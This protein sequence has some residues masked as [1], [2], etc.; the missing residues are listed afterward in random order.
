[1]KIKHTPGPWNVVCIEGLSDWAFLGVGSETSTKAICHIHFEATIEDAKVIIPDE[2]KA[3][4]KLI[5]AAPELLEALQNLMKG[6]EALPSLTAIAGS[7]EKQYK[8]A[9]AA[10][11]KATE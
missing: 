2:C 6:V 5:A 7:L 8:Q 10:I 1:M 3:N 4:A 9:E 11:K